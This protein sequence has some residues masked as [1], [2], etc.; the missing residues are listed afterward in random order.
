MGLHRYETL[1]LRALPGQP[2]CRWGDIKASRTGGTLAHDLA[3]APRP[4]SCVDEHTPRSLTGPPL[5][6]PSTGHDLV[7]SF[8]FTDQPGNWVLPGPRRRRTGGIEWCWREGGSSRRA[9]GCLQAFC[10]RR[11]AVSSRRRCR[12]ASLPRLGFPLWLPRRPVPAVA[13]RRR[14]R[15]PGGYAVPP[16]P[17]RFCHRR[18]LWVAVSLWRVGAEGHPGS[19]A[20]PWPLPLRRC[21]CPPRGHLLAVPAT[22]AP[23]GAPVHKG[24]LRAEAD[25]RLGRQRP[26]ACPAP[27]SSPR[28]VARSQSGA[29]WLVCAWVF[30]PLLE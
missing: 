26:L 16:R 28:W 11:G 1:H 9:G 25:P 12:L 21:V 17:Q 5:P 10:L 15:L 7:P 13:A 30:S 29:L 22:P 24:R 27:L 18:A 20:C 6:A 19:R 8:S 14:H 23:A 4:L 3:M 2:N